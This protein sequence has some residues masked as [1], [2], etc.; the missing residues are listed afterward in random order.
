MTHATEH[1]PM[2]RPLTGSAVFVLIWLVVA[3]ASPTTTFH[4]APAIVAIWP[5]LTGDGR[6]KVFY[7]AT[8]FLVAASATVLLS[9][10]GM[11]QG[12]TLLPWGGP[13]VES[14]FA[15]GVGASVGVLISSG[16][17]RER[18]ITFEGS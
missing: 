16:K 13:A 2:W 5:A 14:V 18:A 4:L 8:G 1:N 15:A 9:A 17:V 6:R 3:L 11:L 7:S 10:T 12:P